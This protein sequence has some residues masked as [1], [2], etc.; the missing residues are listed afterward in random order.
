MYVLGRLTLSSQIHTSTSHYGGMVGG[1]NATTCNSIC[2]SCILARALDN[3]NS[4]HHCHDDLDL[5]DIEQLG[6]TIKFKN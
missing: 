1:G 5:T 2:N 3:V 4:D 6:L